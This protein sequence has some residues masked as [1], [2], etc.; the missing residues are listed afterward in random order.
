MARSQTQ[1]GP[2]K[3]PLANIEMDIIWKTG[4]WRA[5]EYLIVEGEL[6]EMNFTKYKTEIEL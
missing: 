4:S 5:K 2:G 6:G 1:N 3:Y